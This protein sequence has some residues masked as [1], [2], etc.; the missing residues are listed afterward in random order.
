[1][2]KIN[3]L[4]FT[5]SII[6]WYGKFCIENGSNVLLNQVCGLI[7]IFL[8]VKRYVKNDISL[9]LV[10]TGSYFI[11]INKP[12]KSFFVTI[13]LFLILAL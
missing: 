13:A 8:V 5:L 1:M 10:Y 9:I 11:N 3:K 12:S 2:I 7:Y 6:L 4:I